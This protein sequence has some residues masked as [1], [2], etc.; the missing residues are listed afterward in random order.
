MRGRF[1]SAQ[2]IVDDQS[3]DVFEEV[4]EPLLKGIGCGV[5]GNRPA[6]ENLLDRRQLPLWREEAL[7][8]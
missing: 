5:Q 8:T 1:A 4:A 2:C 3:F 7:F 6:G